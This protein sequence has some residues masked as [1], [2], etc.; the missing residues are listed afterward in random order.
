MSFQDLKAWNSVHENP[1]SVG[2]SPNTNNNIF[3]FR[4]RKL[5]PTTMAGAAPGYVKRGAE[6]QK[7]GRVADITWK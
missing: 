7:G 2:V 6:I 3:I 1:K 5:R 4:P